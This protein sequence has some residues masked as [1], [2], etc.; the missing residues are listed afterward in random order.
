MTAASLRGAP[1]RT[2][3]RVGSTELIRLVL[4]QH[5]TQLIVT[6]VVCAAVVA[7]LVTWQGK[8][9]DFVA[10]INISRVADYDVVA[11]SF[12]VAMLWGAPLLSREY[13]QRTHL[14]VWSQDVSAARW[15][16][17][18]VALLGPIL[19][20]LTAGL[21]VANELAYDRIQFLLHSD[22]MANAFLLGFEG[23]VLVQVGY[24][25]AAFAIGVAIGGLSRIPVVAMVVSG[26]VFAVLRW[27][28]A[29]WL[30]GVYLPTIDANS[31]VGPADETAALQRNLHTGRLIEFA[32]YV[33]IAAL[34]LTYAW[35]GVRR[36]QKF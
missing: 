27:A 4:R 14:L 10:I 6:T 7:F 35:F 5:R 28:I 26:I 22:G 33:V 8:P 9:G 21:E 16:L 1:V 25:L 18:K 11:L 15:L 34:A 32:I 23:S 31:V 30:R 19:V 24:A 3:G 13:E 2:T 12:V 29:I 36:R 17:T 20:V